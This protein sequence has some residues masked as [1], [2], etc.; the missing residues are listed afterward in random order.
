MTAD[1]VL[2]KLARREKQVVVM[3]ACGMRSKEVANILNISH[4]SVNTYKTNAERK[5]NVKGS[6]EIAHVMLAAGVVEFKLPSWF[7]GASGNIGRSTL[8]GGTNDRL[9][10]VPLIIG[11]TMGC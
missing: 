6:V 10:K 7:V 4:K 5:L 9:D 8:P 3:L 2:G 1:E 11:E